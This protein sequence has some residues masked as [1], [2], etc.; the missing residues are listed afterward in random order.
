M[1]PPTGPTLTWWGA[2]R[3]QSVLRGTQPTGPGIS[4]SES[5]PPE[6]PLTLTGWGGRYGNHLLTPANGPRRTLQ[7]T[8]GEPIAPGVP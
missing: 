5:E 7:T 3:L 4:L 6:P 2:H 8:T 1:F